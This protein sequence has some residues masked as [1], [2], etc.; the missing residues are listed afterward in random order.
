M[1]AAPAGHTR[2]GFD[3]KSATLPLIAVVLKTGDLSALAAELKA[4]FGDTPDF[5]DQDP[6]VINL[7]QLPE[8]T[9]TIDFAKLNTLLRKYRM[10]PIAVHGGTSAQLGAAA[11]AG[12]VETPDIAHTLPLAAAEP[13]PA[14]P[15][16]EAPAPASAAGTL[17]ID[18]PLR[19]GQQIY[20]RGADLV[21]LA[22]VNFGAE[23]IADGN[24]HVYGPLRGRAIA[25]A[26]GNTGARIFSTCLEAQLISIAGTYRTSEIAMPPE[27]LGKAAQVRLIGEKL[28]M[29]AL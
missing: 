24:I 25:G 27:V 9:G 8:D 3:L 13:A 10:R 22:V 18:K 26:R 5:F 21:V 20:A 12:L 7:A 19:S 14:A 16:E 1:S 23:V 29:E 17:V 11:A 2:A 15:A 6:V 28:V 4:R